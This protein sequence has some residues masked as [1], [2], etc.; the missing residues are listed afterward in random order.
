MTET[1]LFEKEIS[2]LYALTKQVN[3]YLN[4]SLI[5]FLKPGQQE[6]AED[7]LALNCE[8][9]ER[10]TQHLQ[11]QKINPGN[12]IDSIVRE[13]TENLEN[14]AEGKMD[15]PVKAKGYTMSLNRLF[16]YQLANLENVKTLSGDPKFNGELAQYH[17]RVKTLKQ[18]LF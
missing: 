18:K 16:S 7:F 9:E 8:L 2:N 17:Q 1:E 3:E 4:G 15:E 5:S 12:T 6:I 13:I 14:I 11:D 10:L